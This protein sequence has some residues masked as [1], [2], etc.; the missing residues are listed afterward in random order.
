[1]LIAIFRYQF[2]PM[3][4]TDDFWRHAGRTT[5]N[6]FQRQ[7]TELKINPIF[8]KNRIF[9][10]F[11]LS[12]TSIPNRGIEY[13]PISSILSAFIPAMESK[14]LALDDDV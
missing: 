3:F 9:L 2:N 8:P 5:H 4:I 10:D 1:M 12:N 11:I 6:A 13:Q 14:A 7:R